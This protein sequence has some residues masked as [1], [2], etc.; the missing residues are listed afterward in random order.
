M[1]AD[2]SSQSVTLDVMDMWVTG[3]VSSLNMKYICVCTHCDKSVWSQWAEGF[4]QRCL[5]SDSDLIQR[6]CGCW[7]TS[8]WAAAVFALPPFVFLPS[9]HH[10]LYVSILKPF[11]H[12]SFRFAHFILPAFTVWV[13]NMVLPNVDVS[14]LTG[15]DLKCVAGIYFSIR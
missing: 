3:E 13:L 11:T 12:F 9:L 15:W 14:S 8:E 4:E 2:D 5:C 6:E 7:Q 1:S 10:E